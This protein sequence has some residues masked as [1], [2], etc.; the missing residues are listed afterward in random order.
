MTDTPALPVGYSTVP[1]GHLASV[2]TYLEMTS[3]P[4]S[5][6]V[7]ELGAT[8]TLHRLGAAE[9]DRYRALFRAVG[10]RWLWFSRL[11]LSDE[12]LTA[13]LG[14]PQVYVWAVQEGDQSVGLLELDFREADACE[15]A[16]FGLIDRMV[17]RGAGRWLMDEAI[18]RAWAHP[19][20]RFHVHTCTLDHPGAV[21]FYQRS[22]FVAYRRAVEIARDP[23]ITGELGLDAGSD[24]PVIAG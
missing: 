5:R 12:A 17:G 7:P 1:P 16:F 4:T 23:R 10:T 22:G 2:V 3:R 11:R 24:V 15:L 19:I 13:I 6:P 20:R 18:T 21:A 8:L 9:L 14:D